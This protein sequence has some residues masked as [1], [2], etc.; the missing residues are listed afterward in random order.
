MIKTQKKDGQ[1]D[2]QRFSDI[3]SFDKGK[4]TIIL[5]KNKK[6]LYVVV[7]DGRFMFKFQDSNK[8]EYLYYRSWVLKPYV[9]PNPNR[10]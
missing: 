8:T 3:R 6:K 1:L 9:T 7:L 2:Y 4:E 10:K 5:G